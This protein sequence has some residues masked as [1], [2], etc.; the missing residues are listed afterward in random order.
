MNPSVVDIYV[1]GIKNGK[2]NVAECETIVKMIDELVNNAARDKTSTTITIGVISL[3]GEEQSRLIRNRLLDEI[4]PDA[5]TAH[6]ILVGDAP[7]FQGTER[8]VVFLSM[9]C[10]PGKVPTQN[11]LMHAQ[12]INVAMS[13]ARNRLVL[14][15]SLSSLSQIPSRTDFKF[16]VMDFFGKHSSKNFK[17]STNQSTNE[18]KNDFC[19]V[20]E[21]FAQFL[22]NHILKDYFIRDM[23]SVWPNGVL[24]EDPQSGCR[25][26]INIENFREGEWLKILNQQRALESVG[27]QCMRVSP[28]SLLFDIDRTGKILKD[29]VSSCGIAEHVPDVIKDS[30]DVQEILAENFAD[31]VESFNDRNDGS[32][33]STIYI[34]SDD[35]TVDLKIDNVVSRKKYEVNNNLQDLSLEITSSC[36]NEIFGV[37]VDLEFEMMHGNDNQIID[38]AD[39]S[40][41]TKRHSNDDR[42]LLSSKRQRQS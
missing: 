21:N 34:S 16:A 30:S 40:P 38:N 23:S 29:F 26:A 20:I 4:G 15:R 7:A 11:Q 3:I 33:R 27:W 13:R 41:E 22:G 31:R 5:F 14:V 18:L 25:C 39:V 17:L 6:K 9:V 8:D 42:V 19:G 10:S 37:P 2:E 28:I 1:P 36:P 12:R 32:E 35:E 24:I